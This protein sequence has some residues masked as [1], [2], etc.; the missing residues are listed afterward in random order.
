VAGQPLAQADKGGADVLGGAREGHPDELAAAGRVEVVAGHDGDPGVGE[1]PL[2]PGHRVGGQRAD[3]GVGV[4]GAVGRGEPVDAELRQTGQQ[5]VAVGAVAGD[6][7]V[8]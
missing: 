2:A 5:Q 8:A 7:T 6:V 3:V 1:Q 4:E